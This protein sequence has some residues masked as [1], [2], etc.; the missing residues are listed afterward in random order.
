MPV[1]ECARCNELYYSAHAARGLTCDAC[2]GG[3][4]RIF[5]QEASFARVVGLP[6]TFQPGDHGVIIYTSPAEAAGFCAAYLREGLARGERVTMVVPDELRVEVESSLPM[7]ELARLDVR[8]PRALYSGFDRE[9]VVERFEALVRASEQPFRLLS[10]PSSECVAGVDS[11]TW[12]RFERM[13]HELTLELNAITLCAYDS[14]RLPLAFS[15][16]AVEEHPLISREG[17]ELRRNADF[18]YE[19]AA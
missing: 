5:P 17:A 18:R 13:A 12:R 15:P 14:R 7:E 10:G 6:R 2:G 19:R 3:T 4:W 8:D 9:T 1:L 11:S 16:L